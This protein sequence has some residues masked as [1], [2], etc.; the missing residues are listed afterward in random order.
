MEL[1][2]RSGIMPTEKLAAFAIEL[3]SAN[4][5][6]ATLIFRNIP[7]PFATASAACNKLWLKKVI[8]KTPA[9]R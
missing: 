3:A 9:K 7:D 4:T 8:V 1:T 6:G 2:R 5:W